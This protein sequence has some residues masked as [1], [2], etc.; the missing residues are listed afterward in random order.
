MEHLLCGAWWQALAHC[1]GPDGETEAGEAGAV[2]ISAGLHS[3][4]GVLAAA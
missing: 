4:P 2:S 1:R 3:G